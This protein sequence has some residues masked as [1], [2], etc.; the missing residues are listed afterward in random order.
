MRWHRK[1]QGASL[2]PVSR[3]TPQRRRGQAVLEFALIAIVL[4]LLMATII[5][6][7][8]LLH[9][10]QTVQTIVDQA[11]REVSRVPLSSTTTFA[12]A[13]T[14]PRV[15]AIYSEDYLAIDLTAWTDSSQTLLGFL[16]SQTPSVP[17]VNQA[18]LPLMFVDSVG[19]KPL[20]RFPGA[21]VTSSTAPSGY[22]VKVPI[23]TANSPPGGPE[24]IEWHDVL[25]EVQDS[26]GNGPFSVAWID[27]SGTN[28]LPGGMVA[29]RLNYAFEAATMAGYQAQPLD[30]NG[31][32]VPN[33]SYPIVADDGAV[34]AVNSPNGGGSPVSPD[35]P[36]PDEQSG[37]AYAGPYG[38]TYGLGEMG[39]QLQTVRPFRKVISAQA[40]F[41]REVFG[42]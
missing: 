2:R 39:L 29:L 22:T 9:G 16:Q 31:E 8:R 30:A 13:L 18:M 3:A 6:F 4:Y 25:E 38:G 21:L 12:A 33:L 35:L 37:A 11:A 5:E 17:L 41:R 36:P 7:G 20:L 27:S 15:Q 24:S 40:I 34:T 1:P 23:V 32:T 14:D 19:G 26:S 10:S 42:P 28:P